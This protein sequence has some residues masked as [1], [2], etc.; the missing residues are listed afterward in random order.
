LSTAD[1]PA[2]DAASLVRSVLD[3]RLLD[4]FVVV[5]CLD[6]ARV[7]VGGLSSLEGSRRHGAR[8][9]HYALIGRLTTDPRQ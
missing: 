4:E 8:G 1:G 7:S 9:G 5:A 3:D 6:V 2:G